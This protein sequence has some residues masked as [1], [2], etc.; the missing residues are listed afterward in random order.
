MIFNTH[1]LYYLLIYVYMY[2]LVLTERA[3]LLIITLETLFYFSC[4][5]INDK[6]MCFVFIAK[7]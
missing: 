3:I 1:F 7:T 5:L 2:Q 4:K 6:I